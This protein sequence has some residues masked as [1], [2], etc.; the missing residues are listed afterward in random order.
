MSIRRLSKWQEPKV[1][2]PA[3]NQFPMLL[4]GSERRVEARR[5]AFRQ[6]G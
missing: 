3:G 1:E 5:S 2:V 4:L 6:T